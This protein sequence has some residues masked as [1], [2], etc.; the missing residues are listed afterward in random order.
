LSK[1]ETFSSC[2]I[3]SIKIDIDI[4]SIPSSLIEVPMTEAT[5]YVFA[6]NGLFNSN[7]Y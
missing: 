3:F 2:K 4:I 7:P 6:L 1:S 5:G